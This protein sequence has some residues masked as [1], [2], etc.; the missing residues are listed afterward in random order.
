MSTDNRQRRVPA[1]D[2]ID[3]F[4]YVVV[5]NLAVQFVPAVLSETFTLSLLTAVLLKAVL[6]VVVA[7]KGRVKHL[8]KAAVRPVGK[9]RVRPAS[10]V[11]AGGQQVRC[12]GTSGLGVRRSGQSGRVLGRHRAD[13]R[14]PAI[15]GRR[16]VAAQGR[17]PI[18]SA[19][20]GRHGPEASP[21]PRSRR[22][23]VADR[24]PA[25]SFRSGLR[26]AH[27]VGVRPGRVL[28]VE[29]LGYRSQDRSAVP[30]LCVL[31]AAAAEVT[32]A[33]ARPAPRTEAL[34]DPGRGG[35]SYLPRRTVVAAVTQRLATPISG[36]PDRIQ[37]LV[38]GKGHSAR[39]ASS[40]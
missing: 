24:G 13:L 27:V 30:P 25:G 3:V 16:P 18:R 15:A 28:G 26:P 29:V 22:Q 31:R 23:D 19:T 35:S 39:H 7:L 10:V 4:V 2:I 32:P 11:V 5:L 6:E 14:A 33:A 8:F 21:W 12:A 20:T 34:D 1:A 40:L 36:G 37:N 9:G 38:L 17:T